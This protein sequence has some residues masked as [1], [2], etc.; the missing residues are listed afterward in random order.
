MS[1][2]NAS[3][4][5]IKMMHIAAQ[6]RLMEVIGGTRLRIIVIMCGK[7]HSK[8]MV[9][10]YVKVPRIRVLCIAT[11]STLKNQKSRKWAHW[12]AVCCTSLPIDCPFLGLWWL[13]WK[14]SIEMYLVSLST[15]D[16]TVLEPLSLGHKVLLNECCVLSYWRAG[17]LRMY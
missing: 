2:N 5:C 14:A 13:A 9:T 17:T 11:N 1:F 10:N 7:A 6:F 12:S 15:I 3:T 16:K 8:S 4:N